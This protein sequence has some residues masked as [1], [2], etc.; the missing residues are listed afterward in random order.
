MTV[1]ELAPYL[2]AHWSALREALLATYQPSA[3]K[4]HLIPKS[5]GG[6]WWAAALGATQPALPGRYFERLGVPRLAA[7]TSTH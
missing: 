4:R 6:I 3:V 7:S 5:G 1:E 2:R